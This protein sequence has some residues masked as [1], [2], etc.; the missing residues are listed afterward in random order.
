MILAR[1]DKLLQYR[2]RRVALA[3][4]YG[5]SQPARFGVSA[6]VAAIGT[7]AH[8]PHLTQRFRRLELLWDC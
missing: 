6:I 2:S 8:L 1:I 5:K 4:A 7:G 3:F